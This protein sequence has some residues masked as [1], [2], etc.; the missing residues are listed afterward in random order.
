MKM[1][2]K[3]H[4]VVSIS[5]LVVLFFILKFYRK[6]AYDMQDLYLGLV[7]AHRRTCNPANKKVRQVPSDWRD[8][9]LADLQALG[10]D[11]DGYRIEAEAQA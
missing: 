11:A 1:A 10:Y 5:T 8:E 7:R 4:K 2:T 9:V 3:L 6:G